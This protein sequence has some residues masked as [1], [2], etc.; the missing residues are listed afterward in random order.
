MSGSYFTRME[1]PIRLVD[2]DI[3]QT[4]KEEVFSYRNVADGDVEALKIRLHEESI[5]GSKGITWIEDDTRNGE[6]EKLEALL[7]K[8]KIPFDRYTGEGEEY[9]AERVYYRSDLNIDAR[10]EETYSGAEYI[11]L[12]D[13]RNIIKNAK[14]LEKELKEWLSEN[15]AQDIPSIEKYEHET[16]LGSNDISMFEIEQV[17]VRL[18]TG[19]I[20]QK[21]AFKQIAEIRKRSE[22][23]GQN[24]EEVSSG[25]ESA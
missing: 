10:I 23:D 17:L 25:R 8:K 20:D 24:T 18:D 2:E 3:L 14:D 21:E 22:E 12:P 19:E 5:D 4:L 1:F 13:L 11:T 6:F 15:S 16:A 9:S 7:R